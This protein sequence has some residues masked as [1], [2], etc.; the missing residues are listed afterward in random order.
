MYPL[1]SRNRKKKKPALKGRAEGLISATK[2]VGALKCRR[3]SRAAAATVSLKKSSR[4]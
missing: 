1:L 4:G 2:K 3:E